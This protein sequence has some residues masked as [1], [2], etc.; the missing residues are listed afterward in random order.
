[1]IKSIFGK[2][3]I[4]NV[5]K[6]PV[7]KK[8]CALFRHLIKHLFID[9]DGNGKHE[10]VAYDSNFCLKKVLT[11]FFNLRKNKKGKRGTNPCFFIALIDVI[12]YCS[13]Q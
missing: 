8:R 1:M 7:L 2:V 5:R 11:L 13:M 6:L 4:K 9:G 3:L 10:Y 12:L